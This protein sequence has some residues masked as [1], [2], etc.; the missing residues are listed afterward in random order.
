[1]TVDGTISDSDMN[2]KAD[3]VVGEGVGY[4]SQ[5]FPNPANDW[6]LEVV[7]TPGVCVCVWKLF[8]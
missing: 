7:T 3:S 8:V 4:I 2:L 1:M 6:Q 5:P